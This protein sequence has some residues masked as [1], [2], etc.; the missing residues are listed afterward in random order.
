MIGTWHQQQ[1]K[2]LESRRLWLVMLSKS[3]MTRHEVALHVDMAP[4]KF[5]K[6]L[7]HWGIEFP[8]DETAPKRL[9]NKGFLLNAVARGLSKTEAGA[10]VGLSPQIVFYHSKRLGVVFPKKSDR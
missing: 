6:L 3:G 7:V 8:E 2:E 9:L 10:E 5:N 4:S 1:T